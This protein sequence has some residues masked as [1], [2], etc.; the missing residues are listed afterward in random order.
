[1]EGAEAGAAAAAAAAAVVP[2]TAGVQVMEEGNWNQY[3][4]LLCLFCPCFT[5]SLCIS[6]HIHLPCYSDY[7]LYDVAKLIF[8]ILNLHT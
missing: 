4:L 1:V 2:D 7:N 8:I 5:D 3:C 6:V